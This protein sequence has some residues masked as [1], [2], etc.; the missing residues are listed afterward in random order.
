M[1]GLKGT[2]GEVLILASYKFHCIRIHMIIIWC[3][4]Q[5]M[6]KSKEDPFCRQISAALPRHLSSLVSKGSMVLASW[7]SMPLN[8][9]SGMIK[10]Y[11]NKR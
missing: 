1:D 5:V 4:I 3:K 10:G 8:G 6:I 2:D 7:V 9:I 11:D